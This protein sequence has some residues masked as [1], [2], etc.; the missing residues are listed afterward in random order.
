VNRSLILCWTLA[1]LL[2]VTGCKGKDPVEPGPEEPAGDVEPAAPE[3]T[4][5]PDEDDPSAPLQMRTIEI[6]FPSAQKNGLVREFREIFDTATPGDRVKQIIAD[7]I[8][9]PTSDDALRVLPPG[10]QLRQ[11]YVLDD[12][13]A[14]LDFSPEL[15]EGI[16]GGSMA[17]ILVVYSIIDSVVVNIPEIER[18]GILVNGRPLTTLNGHLDL[19]RALPA[20]YKL[21]IG[22]IIARRSEE[23]ATE[24]LAQARVEDEPFH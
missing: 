16:G 18:V 10:T 20:D 3:E 12:G 2:A 22:S 1:V 14:Y 15:T 8:S 13:V 7:L 5:E 24:Y 11:A 4:D 17:E 6:Y 21:I 23:R 19:R 9:G